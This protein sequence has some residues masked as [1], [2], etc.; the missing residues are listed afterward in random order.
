MQ[1]PPN[2]YHWDRH[3]LSPEV[4]LPRAPL[5][6]EA[7]TQLLRGGGLVLLGGRGMGKSVFLRQLKRHL[8]TRPGVAVFVR[9]E[10][11]IDGSMQGALA[12]LA[13]MLG[14]QADPASTAGDLLQQFFEL[15]KDV[16]TVILLFDEL[17][18]YAIGETGGLSP[19]GR[20]WFDHLETVR[21]RDGRLGL[22][23][24]G[25][26][27]VFLLRH[28]L[29]SDFL[30]RAELKKI[31][32]FS[33]EDITRLAQP[34]TT[35]GVPLTSEVLETIRLGSGGNPAL[36]TYALQSLWD[37]GERSPDM[38]RNIYARFQRDHHEFVRSALRALT[39]ETISDAPTRILERIREAGGAV[40]REQLLEVT[41]AQPGTRL[42]LQDIFDLLE[43]AG[44][45]RLDGSTAD[46][47]VR[48]HPIASILN[49]ERV[50]S[51]RGNFEQGLISDLQEL[52]ARM[53]AMGVDLLRSSDKAR[54]LLP[55]AVY[56]AFLALGLTL[57]G[58][59]VEREAQHGAGRTDLKVWRPG[60][61]PRGIIEVKLW[62][63]NDH[64]QIH[65]QVCSYWSDQVV[66]GAAVM[67]TE[68]E[69]PRWED[70]YRADCLSAPGLAV[71][72]GDVK[73]PVRAHFE[74]TSR[75]ADG[76]GARV[77]H[78]LLRIPRRED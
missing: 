42:D 62:G 68:R 45:I 47:P 74:A 52:L 56:S 71:T 58:W 10:P 65:Q 70:E 2:P 61:K 1:R 29:S 5:L 41:S 19:L 9:E 33:A 36:T 72:Q 73:A 17:D 76:A 14:A 48:V 18:Q 54:V 77:H 32:P 13:R 34:F 38:V 24:A 30:S 23:A 27:G 64:A 55:E 66:F 57:K 67:L 46:D 50:S 40:A 20:R 63:R 4:E 78:F 60:T 22:L 43:A 49:L 51:F 16:T 44:L 69:I 37:V 31:T 6:E 75:T 8:E 3:S 35:A 28:S 26:L 59:E 11:P 21:K 53:H 7:S 25:G 12:N 15:R 39:A